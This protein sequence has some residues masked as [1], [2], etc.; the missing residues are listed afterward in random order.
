MYS[1][2]LRA[3]SGCTQDVLMCTQLEYNHK[4]NEYIVPYPVLT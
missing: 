2:V 1:R 3:Y 4:F